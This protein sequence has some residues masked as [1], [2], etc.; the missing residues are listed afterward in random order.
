VTDIPKKDSTMGQKYGYCAETYPYICNIK[1]YVLVGFCMIA[2]EW[3]T[4][5]SSSSPYVFVGQ[6]QGIAVQVERVAAK[7]KFAPSFF[8]DNLWKPP[9]ANCVELVTLGKYPPHDCF[10][11]GTGYREPAPN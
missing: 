9:C 2:L 6:V 7:T 8:D 4:D 3:F 5:E 1:T 11:H 10:P